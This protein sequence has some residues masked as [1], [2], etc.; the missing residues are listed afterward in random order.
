M[1]SS[2][3]NQRYVLASSN[4]SYQEL[5]SMICKAFQ[6]KTPTKIASKSLLSIGW[7]FDWVLSKLLGR[8]RRLTKQLSETLLKKSIY[9]SDKI[10]KDLKE[11][12]F[13]P[14]TDSVSATCRFFLEEVGS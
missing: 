8:K 3:E 7:R 4:A 6:V 10:K 12:E 14:I 11:F 13:I 5:I 1:H 9:S 2:I